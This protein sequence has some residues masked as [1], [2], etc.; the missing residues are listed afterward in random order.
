MF[1]A[2]KDLLLPQVCSLC[3]HGDEPLCRQCLDLWSGPAEQCARI[4]GVP[5]FAARPY[6][7]LA[8]SV[9]VGA[10]DRHR[11]WLFPLLVAAMAASVRSVLAH[12]NGGLDNEGLEVT[13]VPMPSSPSSLR[14]RGDDVVL[15]LARRTAQQLRSEGFL[16]RAVP[17]L[18]HQRKV[19]DQSELTLQQRQLNL[20]GAFALV[21]QTGLNQRRHGG[22]IVVDDVITT[23]ASMREALRTLNSA[24]TLGGACA[25][26]TSLRVGRRAA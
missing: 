20:D 9:I 18:R 16:I 26:A 14:R 6:D 25:A 11:R 17:L 5:I 13:L 1:A 19:K 21:N 4:S 2:L 24:R 10:K 15:A 7:S 23:G 12:H 8:A 22:L 3:R